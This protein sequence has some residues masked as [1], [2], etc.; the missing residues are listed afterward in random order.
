M[1]LLSLKCPDEDFFYITDQL[2]VISSVE[3]QSIMGKHPAG[4]GLYPA[5]FSPGPLIA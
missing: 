1:E 3:E 4:P 2:S 5:C